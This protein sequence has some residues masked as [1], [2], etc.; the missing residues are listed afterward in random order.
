MQGWTRFIRAYRELECQQ[1][2]DRGSAEVPRAIRSRHSGQSV[3]LDS[4]L[5]ET[6]HENQVM[7][8]LVNVSRTLQNMVVALE[9][10]GTI[11]T[12]KQLLGAIALKKQAWVQ[13]RER[14]I[15]EIQLENEKRQ[16]STIVAITAEE[17]LRQQHQQ[18]QGQQRQ[19]QG[20]RPKWVRRLSIGTSSK[21][22][23]GMNTTAI[24]GSG[25]FTPSGGS[26]ST[27]AM[28]SATATTMGREEGRRRTAFKTVLK[29]LSS[30]R[31]HLE[32]PP[33]CSSYK[34]SRTSMDNILYSAPGKQ[35][36]PLPSELPDYLFMNSE[37]QKQFNDVSPS[38]TTA[39]AGLRLKTASFTQDGRGEFV[40]VPLASGLRLGSITCPQLPT[41]GIR[42]SSED[43]TKT[44]AQ[45]ETE[46]IENAE[47]EFW[48]EFEGLCESIDIAIT[49]PIDHNPKGKA[50]KVNA[51][52]TDAESRIRM[53]DVPYPGIALLNLEDL[54]HNLE[55][56]ERYVV[57]L[58]TQAAKHYA[59]MTQKVESSSLFVKSSWDVAV[60]VL[61]ASVGGAFV[62]HGFINVMLAE[63]AKAIT[64]ETVLVWKR[65]ESKEQYERSDHGKGVSKRK[66]LPALIS[67]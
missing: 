15:A 13:E 63:W 61:E 18:E 5:F 58:E 35:R 34:P 31:S 49:T 67:Q 20:Q 23:V 22:S 50:R 38:S 19:R 11:L 29:K 48:R 26:T 24:I 43:R 46:R 9:A 8:A 55:I 54:V 30:K 59:S 41:F 1:S 39:M 51:E 3:T 6:G 66:S 14:R 57:K 62:H 45:Q 21:N 65:S 7:E 28:A 12:P 64:K 40:V 52:G 16:R 25:S 2:S 37:E 53:K 42:L 17:L 4:E 47:R 33:Q 32:T 56:V 44:L 27:V 60:Q 36:D 10:G